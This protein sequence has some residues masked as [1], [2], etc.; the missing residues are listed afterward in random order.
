M[1]TEAD[2]WRLV[3]QYGPL[4][5]QACEPLVVALAG[6]LQSKDIMGLSFLVESA[7]GVLRAA[8]QQAEQI[9]RDAGY[10]TAALQ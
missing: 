8:C 7:D 9:Q 4:T 5:K 6:L 2:K 3:A 10:Y 1:L